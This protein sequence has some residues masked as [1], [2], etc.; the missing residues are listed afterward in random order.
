MSERDA[1]RA[2]LFVR[3]GRF[4]AMVGPKGVIDEP[5]VRWVDDG[6]ERPVLYEGSLSE[7]FV[8]YMDPSPGW[9]PRNFLDAG[10]YTVGGLIKSLMRGTDC[11]DHASYLNMVVV[12][13]DGRPHDVPDAICLYERYAGEPGWRHLAS[14]YEGR[15]KRDLVVRSA[16]VLGNYD[17]IF[18][19]VF[20]QDGSIR[21]ATGATGIAEAKTV[22]PA[23]ALAA[24]PVNNNGSSGPNGRTANA[25]PAPRADAYGR[26]VDGHIVAVNHDHYF[27]YRLDLDVDGPVNTVRNDVLKTETLPADHP[28]RSV[29][30]HAGR[31]AAHGVR[32]EADGGHAQP[33]ALACHQ[34]K[35]REPQRLRDQLPAGARHERAHAAH[36]R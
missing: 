16:A 19:W 24:A 26:F 20:Q 12:G 5:L 21:V 10:E 25:S 35:H 27:S 34:R 9:Y 32:S 13:D 8:P 33:V 2:A 4:L 31:A 22:V 1:R 36:R 14:T 23:K 30:G 17:Y 29:L 3:A 6:R 28:R 15:P 18:D 11:P 7:I